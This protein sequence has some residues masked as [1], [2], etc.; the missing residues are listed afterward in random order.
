MKE[1][2]YALCLL[3]LVACS[4]KKTPTQSAT[5]DTLQPPVGISRPSNTR[6]E[7]DTQATAPQ[8]WAYSQSTDQS[9]SPVYKAALRSPSALRFGFPYEGLSTATLTIRQKTGSTTVYLEVSQGQ[10]NRSF[11]GGS[12]RIRFDQQPPV[13]YAFSAAENGRANIIFFDAE[14]ALIDRIKAARS[15][16]ITVGFDNQGERQ[17]TF[18]T[19]G[20]R[21]NH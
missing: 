15:L 11:Q 10:F 18:P 17:I 3:T 5:T 8:T 7:P 2:L 9:G 20:L 19:A 16:V 6:P 1:T 4:E 12:A 21:W 14:R 13:T